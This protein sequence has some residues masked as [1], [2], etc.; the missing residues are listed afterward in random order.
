MTTYYKKAELRASLKAFVE[1][2]IEDAVK[3][4]KL[5]QEFI[6]LIKHNFLAK[7]VYFNRQKKTIEIGVND[8]THSSFYPSIKVYSYPVAEVARWLNDT[9]KETDGDLEFYGD[10]LNKSDGFGSSQVILF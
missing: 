9:Y 3:K 7:Y 2:S 5:S 10:I 6:T 8:S 1:R 4:G